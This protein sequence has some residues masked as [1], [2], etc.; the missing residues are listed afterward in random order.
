MID[1]DYDVFGDGRVRILKTPGHTPGHQSLLLKLQVAGTVVLSGDLYHTR[2]NHQYARVP[3]I[4][5]QRADTLA[6]MARIETILKN[7]KARLIIQHDLRD[8]AA[9]PKFPEY[10]N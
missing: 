9:L 10:L 6:S 8:F 4:N 1:G 2:E 7:S 3:T 5:T